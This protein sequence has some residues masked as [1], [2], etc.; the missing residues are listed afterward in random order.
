MQRQTVREL[1]ENLIVDESLAEEEVAEE[2]TN[3]GVKENGF[4]KPKDD[5]DD[6]NTGGGSDIDDIPPQRIVSFSDNRE[7][8]GECFCRE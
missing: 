2:Y 3:G 1:Y 5:Q 6:I 7:L 4:E 8:I